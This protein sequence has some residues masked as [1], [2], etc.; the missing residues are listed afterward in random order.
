MLSKSYYERYASASKSFWYDTSAMLGC[1][2]VCASQSKRV[3]CICYMS[4]RL[5][6]RK[7]CSNQ[8]IEDDAYAERYSKKAVRETRTKIMEFHPKMD[9]APIL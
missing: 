6:H 2:K 1:F 5:G 3:M 9:S 4:R 7:E 8:G